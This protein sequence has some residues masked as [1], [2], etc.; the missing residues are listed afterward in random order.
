MRRIERQ[1]SRNP[2]SRGVI[3]GSNKLKR[4][5]AIRQRHL[6]A[7]AAGQRIGNRGEHS[8]IAVF[9]RSYAGQNIVNGAL[10]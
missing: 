10:F 8:G 5:P 4:P 3:N 9:H 7:A 6:A 2:G 1:G